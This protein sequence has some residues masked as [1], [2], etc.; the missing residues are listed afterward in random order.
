MEYYILEDA[1]THK[2]WLSQFA[3][4]VGTADHL[5]QHQDEA[6]P[7]RDQVERG[8]ALGVD[9]SPATHAI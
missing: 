5:L 6:L 3:L 2:L 7:R 4:I 9:P 1:K 8:Q